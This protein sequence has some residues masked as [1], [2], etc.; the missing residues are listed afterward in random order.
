MK[1]RRWF[2]ELRE[3]RTRA[4]KNQRVL[5]KLNIKGPLFGGDDGAFRELLM[6]SKIYAEYGSGRSTIWVHSNT[7]CKIYSVESDNKWASAV[8]EVIGLSDRLELHLANI[9]PVGGSGRPVSYQ[10]AENF[11]DYTDWI[12]MKDISPDLVLIDG[13]FRVCCFLT[14]LMNAREGTKIVFDDYED[15]P[16]YHFVERHLSYDCLYGR[17]ALFTVPCKDN[18]DHSAIAHDRERFAFVM[19]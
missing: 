6:G 16:H 18:L 7:E 12:W 9:G 4:K 1:E 14:S 19:E 15:R 8:C 13:R 17:Q 11:K 5:D 10:F 2:K 3:Q